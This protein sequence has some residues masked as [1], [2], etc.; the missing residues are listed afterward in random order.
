MEK[1]ELGFQAEINLLEGETF[2]L[3]FKNGNNNGIIMEKTMFFLLK[4]FIQN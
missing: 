3:C 2:N 1:T 4:K